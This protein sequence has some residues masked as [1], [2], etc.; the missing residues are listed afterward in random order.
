MN[1]IFDK[2]VGSIPKPKPEDVARLKELDAQSAKEKTVTVDDYASMPVDKLIQT[3]KQKANPELTSEVLKKLRPAIDSALHSYAPGMETE[4]RIPAAKLTLEA[5]K[6]YDPSY[7][8]APSTHVFT[9]LK[10]L[11]RISSTRSSIIK[12]PE[13]MIM[14][15]MKISKARETF[16][17]EKGREP[18]FAE[19]ADLTGIS[20][21]RI[22]KIDS[23]NQ[24]VSASA[25]INP[26]TQGDTVGTSAV[27]DDDYYEYVYSSVSPVD[28]K[29]MEWT[30]GKGGKVLS[31]MEI[32]RRLRITPAAVS[33]RKNKIQ[34]QLSTVR[35]LL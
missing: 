17:D 16:E 10:R 7:N 35:S 24:T 14:D 22:Q 13:Q 5:L 34:Q 18:S 20:S 25:T 11:N 6:S 8:T 3:W 21:K 31:N 28:Q 9:A 26:E 32:A 27:T 2:I 23:M 4:L 12:Y 1:N 29:I 15:K 33:Q 30:S 19:L